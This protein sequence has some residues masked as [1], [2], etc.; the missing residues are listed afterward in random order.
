MYHKTLETDEAIN[1]VSRISCKAYEYTKDKNAGLIFLQLYDKT[2]EN[3]AMFPNGFS[4]TTIEYREYYIHILPFGNYNLFYIIDEISRKI[5]ILRVL[6]Q[7][8]NWQR[9]LRVDSSYHIRSKAL[10]CLSV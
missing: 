2:I 6:Y 4:T 3:M 10:K 9:I 7:K 8:Q 1:D 5:V